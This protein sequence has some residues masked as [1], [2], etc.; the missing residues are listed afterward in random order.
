MLSDSGHLYVVHFSD[1]VVKVGRTQ[2]IK[3]RLNTHAWQAKH[4]GA[5][6][7]RAW[8]SSSLS[9]WERYDGEH[10]LKKFCKARWPRAWGHEY[11]AGA[12]FCD[13]VNHANGLNNLL[14][15][16][17]DSARRRAELALAELLAA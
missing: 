10:E 11:F 15:M 1:D 16:F 9:Y 14:L 8:I 2:D 6:A 5:A 7:R 13:V 3:Q 17:R 4:R 12:D